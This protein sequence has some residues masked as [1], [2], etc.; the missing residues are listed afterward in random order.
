[1]KA[2][3]IADCDGNGDLHAAGDQQ[4]AAFGYEMSASTIVDSTIAGNVAEQGGGRTSR[5]RG[6][7]SGA[8]SW[9]CAPAR[10][11]PGVAG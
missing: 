6:P 2:E 5:A 4:L 7:S 11:A 8:A 1:M 10:E 9:T 3:T